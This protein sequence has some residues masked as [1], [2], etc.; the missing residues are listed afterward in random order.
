[1]DGIA[2]YTNRQLGCKVGDDR[3]VLATE[4]RNESDIGTSLQ[5]NMMRT[6]GRT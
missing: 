5:K 2:V 3:E 1:M 6:K 4:G